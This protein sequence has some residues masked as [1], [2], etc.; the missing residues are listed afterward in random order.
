ML[1]GTGGT[2]FSLPRVTGNATGVH[3][4]QCTAYKKIPKAC[5]SM[6]PWYQLVSTLADLLGQALHV[7]ERRHGATIFR[8]QALNG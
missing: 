6:Y 1:C 7:G 2:G 4:S 5:L 3:G 8:S